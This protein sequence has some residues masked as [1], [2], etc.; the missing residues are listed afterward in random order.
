[1]ATNYTIKINQKMNKHSI[2]DN[3]HFYHKNTP[4]AS[5]NCNRVLSKKNYDCLCLSLWSC[6]NSCLDVMLGSL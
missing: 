4:H 1:M 6:I 3:D 2:R 5:I